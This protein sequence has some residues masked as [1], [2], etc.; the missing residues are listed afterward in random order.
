[1]S[2]STISL[3]LGLGGGKSATSSGA[4]SGGGGTPFANT[5]SGLFDG[6]DNLDTAAITLTGAKTI[7]LWA[8]AGANWMTAGGAGALLICNDSADWVMYCNYNKYFQ[9]KGGGTNKYVTWG[10][11]YVVGDWYHL[12][13]T[14]DGTTMK[15]YRNTVAPT[16]GLGGTATQANVDPQNLN[17]IGG[18]GSFY[19][20]SNLDE[21]AIWDS[22]L[23]AS[24]VTNIYRGEADGGSGGTNGTPG[25]LSSFSPLHWWRL[26]DGTGDVNASGG[27]PAN[28]GVIGTVVDQGSGGKNATQTTASEQ[29]TFSNVLPA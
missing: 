29:P 28:T 25:D 19:H 10:S 7:S 16:G 26:G 5:L 13:I 1:M 12:V 14:S 3:G 17:R 24:Q 23:S 15:F 21:V 20:Q 22:E 11:N 6:G 4:P 27:T 2:H 9:I 8:K 18:R